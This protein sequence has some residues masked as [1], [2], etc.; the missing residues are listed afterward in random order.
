MK[1]DEA[2]ENVHVSSDYCLLF[3]QT[4]TLG[5][6]Q[7]LDTLGIVQLP[8]TDISRDTVLNDVLVSVLNLRQDSVPDNV[9]D[10]GLGNVQ[11]L[12]TLRTLP[13]LQTLVLVI[14]T[15]TRSNSSKSHNSNSVFNP[16]SQHPL[17]GSGLSRL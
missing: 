13:S 16:H 6:L 12:Q 3:F 8:S 2:R 4:H 1:N 11:R 5:S 14:P 7:S 9:L 15:N 10:S 17:S